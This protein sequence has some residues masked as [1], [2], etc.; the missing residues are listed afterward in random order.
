MVTKDLNCTILTDKLLDLFHEKMLEWRSLLQS[1]G[2]I[3]ELQ[4]SYKLLT[5]QLILT[6]IPCPKRWCANILFSL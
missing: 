6:Q 2:I 3:A 1:D 4:L 5:V